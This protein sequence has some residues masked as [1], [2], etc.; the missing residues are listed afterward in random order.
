M[1]DERRS[2]IRRVVNESGIE[3]KPVY[4]P[5][6]VEQSGGFSFI[7]EPGAYP[8]VRGIHPLMYRHRPYTMRQYT[9]FGNA[10]DTNARE[11]R[12]AA[13]GHRGDKSQGHEPHGAAADLSRPGAD[14]DHGQEMIDAAEGMREARTEALEHAVLV[15]GMGR[16]GDGQQ[17]E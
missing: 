16:S 8:F 2:N 3:I 7:G 1:S 4:T 5:A 17:R 13:Y 6:D 15:S 12:D 14:G 11:A 10:A 9:G